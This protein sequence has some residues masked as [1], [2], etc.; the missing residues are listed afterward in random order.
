MKKAVFVIVLCLVTAI[1]INA[2]YMRL[3]KPAAPTTA[4]ATI[5]SGMISVQVAPGEGF[6]AGALTY[7]G[8]PY[9]IVGRDTTGE[10]WQLEVYNTTGW[11]LDSE[12]SVVNVE[13]VPVIE[14]TPCVNKLSPTCPV[15]LISADITV[16]NFEHGIMLWI[17]EN[18]NTYVLVN[19]EEQRFEYYP[20]EW[21]GR[22]LPQETPSDGFYQPQARF[23]NLW[24]NAPLLRERLGW[25]TDSE[26]VYTTMIEL[27]DGTN[28]APSD[29]VTYI[30][31]PDG[32]AIGLRW[33]SSRWFF[34]E[35]TP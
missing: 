30:S 2:V 8:T 35:E 15:E 7:A 31:L 18:D 21:N 12:V 25:A 11:I 27:S 29:D 10:W 23:G 9:P 19:G 24:L 4:T 26:I 13:N 1:V 5:L 3:V 33:Y 32:R 16:Q 17:H 34:L 6:F 28:Y 20:D 14:T 22:T